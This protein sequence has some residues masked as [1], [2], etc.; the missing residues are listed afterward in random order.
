MKMLYVLEKKVAPDS[1][2]FSRLIVFRTVCRLEEL[3]FELP[4]TGC[5]T[6]HPTGNFVFIP[7]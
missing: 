4:K 3:D 7:D 6:P 1:T 5:R 2:V